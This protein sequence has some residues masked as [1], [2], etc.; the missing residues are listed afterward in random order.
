MYNKALSLDELRKMAGEPVWCKGVLDE[1]G[2][3]GWGEPL[4]MIVNV[5]EECV[6]T[7]SEAADFDNYGGDG[8]LACRSKP[9]EV[10]DSDC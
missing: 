7:A 5:Q 9:E 3:D 10:L 6:E 1:S 2:W 8:W 4:W